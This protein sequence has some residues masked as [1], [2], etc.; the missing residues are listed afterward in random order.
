MI[1]IS[2]YI[3]CFMWDVSTHARPN[4][5]RDWNYPD[6]KVHGA[7][8]GPIWVLS[9]PDGPHIG[10]MNL[11]IRV[12][13][14]RW[15]ITSHINNGWPN[16]RWSPLTNKQKSTGAYLIPYILYIRVSIL[17]PIRDNDYGSTQGSSSSLQHSQRFLDSWIGQMTHAFTVST[18]SILSIAHD[19][20]I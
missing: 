4:F 2:N 3:H 11:A 8:M 7:N 14:H 18:Y 19:T 1:W 12:G 5:D 16:L 20:I 13:L 15:V 17:L 10:P 9:A 6:S